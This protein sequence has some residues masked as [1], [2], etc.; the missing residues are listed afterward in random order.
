MSVVQEASCALFNLEGM[1]KI[2]LQT[3]IKGG[4]VGTHCEVV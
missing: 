3:V 2:D 4:K 1:V